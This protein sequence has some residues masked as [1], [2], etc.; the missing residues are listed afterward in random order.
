MVNMIEIPPSTRIFF[1]HHRSASTWILNILTSIADTLGLQIGKYH[2]IS[3]QMSDHVDIVADVN[4]S[5]DHR[6]QFEDWLGFHVIRDPRD[7]VVSA[8]FSHKHSHPPGDWL[9]E[10]RQRLQHTSLDKGIRLS[11]D[12]RE[13]QFREMSEWDYGADSRIYETKFETITRRTHPEFQHILDFLELYPRSINE[14]Q[15]SEII[16]RHRFEKLAGGR[17]PGQEDVHH[18]YRKGV[19]GDW[20]VYFSE[21]NKTYFKEKWGELLI[22]LGYETDLTW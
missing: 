15:L 22:T 9:N 8:Y 17:E 6:D 1:G 18:H 12:F 13:K 7:I 16:H 11:I 14:H 19:V 10:Q 20:K 21:E 2:E 3:P 4:A 5:W